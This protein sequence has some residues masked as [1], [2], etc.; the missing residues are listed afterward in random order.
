MLNKTYENNLSHMVDL[1]IHWDDVTE[2]LDAEHLWIPSIDAFELL[3]MSFT[4]A[5][6]YLVKMESARRLSF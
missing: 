1:G 2:S 3:F 5:K 4:H 6:D